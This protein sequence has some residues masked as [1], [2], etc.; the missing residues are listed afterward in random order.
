MYIIVEIVF[1]KNWKQNQIIYK[2]YISCIGG[3]HYRPSLGQPY[4]FYLYMPTCLF[5]YLSITKVYKYNNYERKIVRNSKDDIM[6]C[7][8]W[9]LGKPSLNNVLLAIFVL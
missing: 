9:Q 4:D 5:V 3:M 1:Y 8:V 6:M 2:I 7:V